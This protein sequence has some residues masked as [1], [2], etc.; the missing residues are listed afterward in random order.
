MIKYVLKMEMTLSLRRAAVP[1]GKE[2]AEI[3]IASERK[4]VGK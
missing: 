1:D 3:S 2:A 4:W